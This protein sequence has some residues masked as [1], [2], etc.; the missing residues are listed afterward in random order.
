[1]SA[2]SRFEHSIKLQKKNGAQER[3]REEAITQLKIQIDLLGW[4]YDRMSSA[5]QEVYDFIQ[6][7]SKKI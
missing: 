4:D 5:G 6:T 1:M 3:A 2:K 7:L